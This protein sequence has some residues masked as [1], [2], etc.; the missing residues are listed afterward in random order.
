MQEY[1]ANEIQEIYEKG[2]NQ[3]HI[4]LFMNGMNEFRRFSE[5]E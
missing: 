3:R 1:V 5:D 4:H 2:I